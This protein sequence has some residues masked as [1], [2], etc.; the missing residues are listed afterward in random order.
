MIERER[1]AIEVAR[2]YYVD[3]EAMPDLATAYGVSR[4]TISRLI[5][6]ARE[7]DWVRIEIIDPDAHEPESVHSLRERFG[8]ASIT[9]V[10]VRPNVRDLDLVG[11]RAAELLGSMITD[12]QAVG[13]AWGTT[14]GAVAAWLRPAPRVGVTVVQLNGAGSPTDLEVDYSIDI[15]GRFCEAWNASAVHFP[16]PAFFDRADTRTA[17]WQER[18]IK[19][20]LRIQCQC[21]VAVF[22]VGSRKADPPS[23]VYA[24]GYLSTADRRELDDDGAVGDIATHFYDRNGASEQIHI[25]QRASG[26]PPE[27]LRRI[28]R[29]VCVAAGIGKIDALAGALRGGYVTDLVADSE[30]LDG[31]ATACRL[32]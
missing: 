15:L 5:T 18:S 11:H 27:G 25:N 12:H 23:R 20:V 14:T 13:V 6:L 10:T 17:L 32:D 7:R 24:A 8:L 1:L 26:L 3:N 2:R 22:S 16:V 21:D 9:S 28:P 29:R 31:V 30:L 19:R 4:S